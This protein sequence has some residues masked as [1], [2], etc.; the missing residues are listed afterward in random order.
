MAALTKNSAILEYG[1][2]TEI[3]EK[4]ITLSGEQKQR[5][6]IACA[7][8]SQADT[9]ILDYCLSASDAHTAKHLYKHC[10]TG[11]F[12]QDRTVTLVTHHANLCIKGAEYVVALTDSKVAAAGKPQVVV[13]TIMLG[14]E[15]V[16]SSS[17][18]EDTLTT[19]TM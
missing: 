1:D 19:T 2:Q 8:Y 12:L 15:V 4:A 6:S 10:L 13:A 11:E 14:D 18:D 3:G 9:I 7:V 16:L 17:D 5:V